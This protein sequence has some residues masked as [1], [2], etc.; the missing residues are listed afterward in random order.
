[1]KIP[2]LRKIL[3]D[4]TNNEHKFVQLIFL[5][6][7]W[8]NSCNI[9][10]AINELSIEIHWSQLQ[11]IDPFHSFDP[12]Y[13]NIS[14]ITFFVVVLYYSLIGRS[15]NVS[16]I[17]HI[18]NGMRM[19][20]SSFIKTLP[21]Y[22]IEKCNILSEVQRPRS[23]LITSIC[24]RCILFWMVSFHLIHS[25]GLINSLTTSHCECIAIRNNEFHFVGK[26]RIDSILLCFTRSS[27]QERWCHSLSHF[28]FGSVSFSWCYTI[29]ISIS[30][31]L[32]NSFIHRIVE[33]LSLFFAA[34]FMLQNEAL[35]IKFCFSTFESY[36]QCIL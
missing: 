36:F 35:S 1:M 15:N 19:D 27:T 28:Y 2:L 22:T 32:F 8:L 7:D 34:F 30:I 4:N 17:L 3:L 24:T 26:N 10:I 31:S 18:Y 14:C 16:T 20:C 23:C 6:I 25:V 13:M 5:F 33:C 21:S 11:P 29:S 12:E 9:I